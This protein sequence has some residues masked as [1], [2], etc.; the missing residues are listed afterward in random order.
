[1]PFLDNL[2]VEFVILLFMPFYSIDDQN[3]CNFKII[4]ICQYFNVLPLDYKILK[5]VS[6]VSELNKIPGF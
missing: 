3:T 5:G 1:M 4:F 6:A 2:Q